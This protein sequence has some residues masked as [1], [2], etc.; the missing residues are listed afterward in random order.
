VKKVKRSEESRRPRWLWLAAALAGTMLAAVLALRWQ[1]QQRAATPPETRTLMGHGGSVLEVVYS[2]D[3]TMLASV[4]GDTSVRLWDAA[5]GSPTAVLAEHLG[6]VT[7]ASFSY[8]SAILATGGVDQWIILW[9]TKTHER[10]GALPLDKAIHRVVFH[11]TRD[12]LAIS[13]RGG[14]IR[15]WD[16]AQPDMHPLLGHTQTALTLAYSP[17]GTRLVSG[18]LDSTVRVWDVARR[19]EIMRLEAGEPYRINMP[20]V[21]YS[22]DG[23]TILTGDGMFEGSLVRQWSATSGQQTAAYETAGAIHAL[24]Y[25]PDG[26]YIIASTEKQLWFWRVQDGARVAAV[27]V[28]G[29]NQVNSIAVHPG[30]RW[31]ATAGN[32]NNVTLLM[33]EHLMP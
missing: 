13:L 33:I 27:D 1:A 16:I 20:Y 15:L 19:A 14:E 29:A 24:A 6:P 10:I 3:G 4:S 32:S 5:L 2:P 17:D 26:R 30:S 25:S 8:D 22:P 31:I 11:P 7:S 28:P 12:L 23:S 21:A 9:D 18:G